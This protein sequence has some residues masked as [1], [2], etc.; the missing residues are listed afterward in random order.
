[1]EIDKILSNIDE[2]FDSMPRDILEK[3]D[4][5]VSSL[6]I[7]DVSIEEY[8]SSFPESYN[9]LGN[10]H[11][12]EYE[13]SVDCQDIIDKLNKEGHFEDDCHSHEMTTFDVASADETISTGWAVAA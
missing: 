2:F 10:N 4:T 11:I 12:A 9:L 1:M 5:A 6:N 7:D 3:I 13:V 8:L